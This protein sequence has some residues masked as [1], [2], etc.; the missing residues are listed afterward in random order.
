MQLR[1][2]AVTALAGAWVVVAQAVCNDPANWLESPKDGVKVLVGYEQ[3]L[4]GRFA[5]QPA[6]GLD[7]PAFPQSLPQ[8]T[9]G[10]GGQGALPKDED[11]GVVS[12]YEPDGKDGWRVC[13]KE[14]W[15][16]RSEGTRPA[17][18]ARSEKNQS[19]NASLAPLL[20]SHVMGVARVYLYDPNG[21]IQETFL[22]AVY[23]PEKSERVTMHER[24]CFRFNDQNLLQLYVSTTATNACPSGDPDPRDMRRRF[25]YGAF[26]NDRGQSENGSLWIQWHSGKEDGRWSE[27]IVFRDSPKP[28]PERHGGNASVDSG[29][30]VSQIL[31]GFNVG[32]RDRSD[33]P[34]LKYTDGSSQPIEYY[35]TKP[36]V[37]AS[38]LDV[39]EQMY[40]HD[41]RRETQALSGIK[42]IEFYP[43]ARTSHAAASTWRPAEPSA[44]NSTTTRAS[45][46]APTTWVSPG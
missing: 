38:I 34:A 16:Q 7:T 8:D 14:D 12:Y 26:K 4:G 22:A 19:R 11:K 40:R 25:R 31:G 13:R 2:R 23:E 37:P 35:F 39:I 44:R 27:S 21:R 24:Q 15:F 46:S 1:K 3:D 45:S 30:G 33:G 41:R 36:P 18:I 17:S 32:L 6:N 29:K 5:S 9:Q 28:G 10:K 43:Q 20:R 42:L